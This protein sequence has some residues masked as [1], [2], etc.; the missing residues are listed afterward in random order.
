[1]AAPRTRVRLRVSP[2]S[3]SA[4]IAGRHGD[5]WKV[6]VVPPA[7]GGRANAAVVQLLAR[8][9]GVPRSSVAVVSGHGAREKIVE[10]TGVG[11]AETER[12]LAAAGK[13]T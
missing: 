11:L 12:R 10:L 7:E 1:V 13:E 5:A 6:R 3:R 2:G 4:G 8:T 9:L